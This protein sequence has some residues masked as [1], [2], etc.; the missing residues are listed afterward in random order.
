MLQLETPPWHMCGHG[1]VADACHFCM[2]DSRRGYLIPKRERALVDATG[3]SATYGEVMPEGM[4]AMI[5]KLHLGPDSVF[6]GETWTHD[7]RSFPCTWPSVC[8]TVAAK[9]NEVRMFNSPLSFHCMFVQTLA[10]ALG[11]LLCKWH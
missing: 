1:H 4:Q 2:S 7:G 3:G 8:R 11:E 9:C 5:N 6:V 10:Q